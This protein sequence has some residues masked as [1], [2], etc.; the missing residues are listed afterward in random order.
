MS[1]SVEHRAQ[2]AVYC[3]LMSERYDIAVESGLLYYLKT[4]HMQKVPLPV[5][6]KRSL[7]IKRNEMARRLTLE[8]KPAGLPGVDSL[9][10][11]FLDMSFLMSTF[12][13]ILFSAKKSF[14]V[15]YL[16]NWVC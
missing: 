12:E 6:E 14:Y 13:Y 9:F 8:K 16:Y 5:Q 7:L 4:N 10:E 2:V 15:N 3:I 1:G 11:R